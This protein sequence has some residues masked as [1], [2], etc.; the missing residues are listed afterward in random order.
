LPAKGFKIAFKHRTDVPHPFLF[1]IN[2]LK[3]DGSWMPGCNTDI[4][5]NGAPEWQRFETV[6]AAFPAEATACQFT[7]YAAG[8]QEPARPRARCGSTPSR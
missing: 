2:Y 7:L 3:A 1:S 8:Y 6:H 5:V 4:T